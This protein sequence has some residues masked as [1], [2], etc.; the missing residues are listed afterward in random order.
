M[1]ENLGST[2]THVDPEGGDKVQGDRLS[3][4]GFTN[5]A[6]WKESPF[7]FPMVPGPENSCSWGVLGQAGAVNREFTWKTI[8]GKALGAI[9]GEKYFI[10]EP[11]F[12]GMFR[13]ASAQPRRTWGNFFGIAFQLDVRTGWGRPFR[14][15]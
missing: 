12:E 3:R 7:L 11:G 14:F 5:G 4:G 2:L 6:G 8:R 1:Q 15:S 13:P 9:R 10:L